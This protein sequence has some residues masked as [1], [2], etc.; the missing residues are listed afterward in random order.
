MAKESGIEQRCCKWLESQG[1]ECIKV[2]YNGYP[3][4][5]NV[6]RVG[7]QWSLTFWTEYKNVDGR[8]KPGQR[9]RIANLKRK[10]DVVLLVRSLAELKIMV[11]K[12][13]CN[14]TQ[15]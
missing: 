14:E 6:Q 13:Q 12:I 1:W 15:N 4:R 5:L 2:G 8:L 11:A 10:G 7:G 3:D 9:V